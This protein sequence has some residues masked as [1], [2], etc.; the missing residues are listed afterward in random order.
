MDQGYEDDR[1]FERDRALLQ[2]LLDAIPDLVFYK[3]LQFRYLGCNAAFLR[4]AGVS[5]EELLGKDDYD[6]FTP[7]DAT[8]YRSIDRRVI[9]TGVPAAVEEWVPFPDGAR[10]LYETVKT[11]VR[12]ADGRPLCLVGVARDITARKQAAE[13]NERLNELLEQ[14]VQDRTTQLTQTIADLQNEILERILVE[15]GLRLAQR[16]QRALLDSIADLAWLKDGGGRLV[17]V[18][19]PMATA[20]GMSP[21]EMIGKTAFDLFPPEVAERYDGDDREV[22]ELRR[23]KR[24]VESLVGRDGRERWYE[25]IKTPIFDERGEV[26]G[27]AGVAREVTGRADAEEVHRQFVERLEALV[28]ERT[29]HLE[30]ANAALIEEIRERR[31]P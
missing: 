25:T 26:V 10:L 11:L 12:D 31:K 18:N 19:Q 22:L 13:A 9:E 6:L 14:R 4:Y 3:D 1:L 15:S 7:D 5:R 24:I 2:G 17:A 28:R 16:Q 20:A 27:T 21:E 8:W 23:P 30:R 29:A